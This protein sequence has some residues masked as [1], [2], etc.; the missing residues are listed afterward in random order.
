VPL[1]TNDTPQERFQEETGVAPPIV[2]PP[3]V[4]GYPQKEG[5]PIVKKHVGGK[6][7][8]SKNTM[9]TATILEEQHSSNL[10]ANN[11]D[12]L[13]LET[14]SLIEQ[15]ETPLQ[16]QQNQPTVAL[17]QVP[18]PQ[19]ILDTASSHPLEDEERK[20]S[21]H[22][23]S[24]TL[25]STIA[26]SQRPIPQQM[27][28]QQEEHETVLGDIAAST[29]GQ[30]NTVSTKQEDETA[31]SLQHDTSFNDI[32]QHTKTSDIK[33]AAKLTVQAHAV[34]QA[35]PLPPATE[36][37]SLHMKKAL[38]SDEN[39]IRIKMHPISLGAIDIQMD[40]GHDGT[41]KAVL[42]AEKH[43]TFAWLQKDATTLE[44]A[45]ND[46][47]LKLDSQH[48]LSFQFKGNGQGQQPWQH[49]Q[50][51]AANHQKPVLDVDISILASLPTHTL[52][53]PTR[54]LDVH[55]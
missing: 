34:L 55:V 54:V 14:I 1:S 10:L 53:D 43:E 11:D 13:P 24:P 21:I 52:L 46:T 50:Q 27:S 19:K 9:I 22:D 31:V 3:I 23:V 45:I 28:P 18:L 4:Q 25:S 35:P 12:G 32:L 38:D 16:P 47:G 33:T 49:G 40:V 26:P 15:G 39:R 41:I 6:E 17:V 51:Q 2:S 8:P 37:I 36:Q 20:I 44:K 48:G 7:S 29:I 42:A 5:V 30:T